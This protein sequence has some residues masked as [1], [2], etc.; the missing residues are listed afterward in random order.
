LTYVW[1]LGVMVSLYVAVAI[2]LNLVIGE[3]GLLSVCQAAF[4]GIGA[5]TSTLLVMKAHS[6]FVVS[7]GGALVFAALAAICIGLPSLRLRGDYFVLATLGFQ[8]I[9]FS[10]LYNWADLTNGPDGIPGI[11]PPQIF[12]MELANPA[13]YF[14]ASLAMTCIV[15]GLTFRLVKSPFGR[16]M[17]AVRDDELAAA[18]LGKN[19]LAVRLTAFAVGAGLTAVAGAFYAGY[20]RYIDPTSFTV[21]EAIFMVSIVVIGGAGSFWGPVGGAV[22]LVLL[23]EGLRFLQ[24]PDAIAANLRQVIYGMA[25]VLLMRLRPRGIA[26]KY[27]FD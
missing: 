16:L 12:G 27:G 23:P 18:S 6:S 8:I 25:L 19:S 5:Y 11:P 20:A 15:G 7:I 17:K 3:S 10:I 22:V 24:I 13:R 1:H 4:Y 21:M 9:L 26:G 2:S 14:V